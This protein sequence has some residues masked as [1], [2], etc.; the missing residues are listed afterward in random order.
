MIF[1]RYAELKKERPVSD[2]NKMAGSTK[3]QLTSFSLAC[4]G[5]S[6]VFWVEVETLTWVVPVSMFALIVVVFFLLLPLLDRFAIQAA[7]VAVLLWDKV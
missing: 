7:I 6:L 1:E 2:T 5:Y 3:L 4:F